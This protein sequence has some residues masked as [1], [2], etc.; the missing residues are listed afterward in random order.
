MSIYF[1]RTQYMIDGEN[2]I[3]GS[4][5][6]RQQRVSKIGKSACY[7]Q[8]RLRYR[9]QAHYTT[10]GS[11]VADIE[12]FYYVL[13]LNIIVIKKIVA[14]LLACKLVCLHA[15]GSVCMRVGLFACERGSVCMRAGVCWQLRARRRCCRS[16]TR[17]RRVGST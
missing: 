7:Q 15:S 2:Y 17:R 8:R 16:S 12:Q 6:L 4:V 9:R 5:R 1:D 13:I 14:G 3:I 11:V 10:D